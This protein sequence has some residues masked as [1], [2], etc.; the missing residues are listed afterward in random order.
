MMS[1]KLKFCIND[2]TISM[3]ALKKNFISSSCKTEISKNQTLTF[4]LRMAELECKLN[5]QPKNVPC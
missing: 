1:S 4:V 5:Y 3:S 2:L